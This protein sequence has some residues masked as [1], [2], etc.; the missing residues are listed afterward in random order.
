MDKTRVIDLGNG[1][2]YVQVDARRTINFPSLGSYDL[3]TGQG[4]AS[5]DYAKSP[6]AFAC[7]S[8]RA[9]LI[10]QIPWRLVKKGSS[11]GADPQAIITDHPLIDMLNSWGTYGN[12]A[13]TLAA[14]ERDMLLRGAAFWLKNGAQLNRLNTYTI[15]V[16]RNAKGVTGFKQRLLTEGRTVERTFPRDEVMYFREYHPQDD[17]G[18]GVCP[19]DVAKNAIL[20]EYEA[21]RYIKSFFEN[22]ATPALLMHTPQ[23]IQKPDLQKLKDWWDATFKG[24]KKHHKVAWVDKDFEAQLLN[25]DLRS[26]AL[27]EVRDEARRDICAAFHIDPILVG[28]MDRGTYANVEQARTALMKE[29]IAP[30]ADYYSD[31]INAELVEITDP[32]VHFEFAYEKVPILQEDQDKKAE[33]LGLLLDK[34]VISIEYFRKEMGIPEDAGP[35]SDEIQ[36]EAARQFEE[37]ARK[38]QDL[39]KWQKKALKAL[40]AGKSANVAFDTE[41]VPE[42]LRMAIRARLEQAE[43]AAD[44]ELAFTRPY[45]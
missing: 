27:R 34:K 32:N 19:M 18:V 41:E 24:A 43:T 14:T 36:S 35:S 13:D 29:T 31:V 11:G 7:I 21:Q 44:V 10:S 6:C 37:M 30:R 9:S 5:G 22:D 15:S 42:P 25:T 28:S 33:R 3:V 1:Y 26:M 17:L 45:P 8:I 38:P 40:R 20:A 16:E 39:A 2:G 12:W 23:E 4:Y